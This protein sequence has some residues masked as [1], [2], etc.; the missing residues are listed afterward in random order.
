M[1]TN[2]TKIERILNEIQVLTKNGHKPMTLLAVCPNSP[3]VIK[4]AF[5]AAKRNNA[6][7][8]FAATL[9]QVDCDGGYTGMTQKDFVKVVEIES[10]RVNYTGDY[11]V[12]IDHGGPWLKDIQRIEKWSYEKAMAAIKNSFE[13]ALLAGYDLIH[14][15][16]TVDITLPKGQIIKIETVVDR[17]VE[18]ISHIETFRKEQGMDRISFEVG[19]EEVHGGLAD[20]DVFNKFLILLKKGLEEKGCSDAWP[21]FIVGKVGTD[22]DTAFFDPVVAKKLTS[23]V[24]SMEVI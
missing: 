23:T 24:K 14:V 11:I 6:P 7:I 19:T 16:P 22:L 1:N 12:A 20:E 5:R 3:S 8:K 15:D 21:I 4:A 13:K 2:T 10:R 18:L 9:N 17:T